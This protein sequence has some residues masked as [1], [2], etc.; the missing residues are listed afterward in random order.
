ME[1]GRMV[2]LNFVTCWKRSRLTEARQIVKSFFDSDKSNFLGIK[3]TEFNLEQDGR[4]P[5]YLS[6]NVRANIPIAA[7][8]P[9]SDIAVRYADWIYRRFD[10]FDYTV[11]PP[12]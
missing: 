2:L 12:P 11:N 5:E 4:D 8:K 6:L 1:S 7:E 10:F 3:A 9:N